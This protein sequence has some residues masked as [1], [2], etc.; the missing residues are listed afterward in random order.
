MRHF[1][2]FF[3][4]NVWLLKVYSLNFVLEKYQKKTFIQ[5]WHENDFIRQRIDNLFNYVLDFRSG[6]NPKSHYIFLATLFRHFKN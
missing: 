1:P 3:F 5:F 6:N 4:Q 2:D